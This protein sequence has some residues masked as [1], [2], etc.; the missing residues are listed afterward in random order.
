MEASYTQFRENILMALYEEERLEGNGD[1]ILFRKLV[2]EFGLE[3]R[4]GWLIEVQKD[5][6]ADGLITGPS[7]A[8]NDDMAI[9]KL[10]G[11]GLR[12]VEEEYGAIGG[13]P[14]LL[15]KPEHDDLVIQVEEAAPVDRERQTVS[16][17][18]WTGIEARLAT[19][20]AIIE[21]ISI[22]IVEIDRL[23]DATGLTNAERQK[24][25]AITSALQN[26]ILSPEPEWQ[27]IVQ[28]LN[29]PNLTAVL[30][31]AAVV[32]LTLALIFGS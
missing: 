23:I 6:L 19:S 31:V 8:R 1:V 14:T 3:W 18:S 30:N 20:P 2:D 7:N 16:S 21:Q 4:P 24:A 28:L 13:V 10:S 29:S 12:H 9:G 15:T 27:V 22:K 5:L 25:K 26:L 32:Q 11:R 17:S